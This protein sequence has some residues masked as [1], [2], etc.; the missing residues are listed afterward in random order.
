MEMTRGLKVKPPWMG[1]KEAGANP[2]VEKWLAQA[3]SWGKHVACPRRGSRRAQSNTEAEDEGST[4]A[5]NVCFYCGI[6][7]GGAGS[8]LAATRLRDLVCDCR[9]GMC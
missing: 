2:G 6:R 5:G 9:L 3:Q 4:R 1:L 7:E 8:G